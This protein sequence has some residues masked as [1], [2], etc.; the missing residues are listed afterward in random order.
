ME[1]LVAPD[2]PAERANAGSECESFSKTLPVECSPEKRGGGQTGQEDKKGASAPY[3]KRWKAL[4]Q[5]FSSMWFI[6]Y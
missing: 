4:S 3:L 6:S 5:S 2:L 1:L